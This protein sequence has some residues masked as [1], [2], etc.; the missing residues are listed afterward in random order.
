MAFKPHPSSTTPRKLHSSSSSSP[1]TS[2]SSSSSST[3]C[4]CN[5]IIIPTTLLFAL[6]LLFSSSSSSTIPLNLSASLS[7]TTTISRAT[8]PPAA[9]NWTGD[10]RQARFAWN[11]LC[12]GP[13]KAKLR[14]AAFSKKWPVGAVP[15]GMERHALGLYTALARAG[16]TVH[17]FTASPDAS[18]RLIHRASDGDLHVHFASRDGGLLDGAA[19]WK[20]FVEENTSRPFDFVHTESVALQH[21][22]ALTVPNLAATWH[23]IAYEALHSDLF[24]DLL[25]EPGQRRPAQSEARLRETIPKLLGEIRFFASYK[26]HIGI[27]DSVGQVLTDIYQLPPENVHVILNGVDHENFYH[28]PKIGARFRAEFGVPLDASLVMGVAGRL[29][30]DKGHQLL[31]E[32]FSAI[33]KRH[34]DVYLL[35]AG[36]GPWEERYR[37]LEPNVKVLGPLKPSR[38]AEFYNALDVFVNPTLRPQGLDLTLMEA[39]HCGKPLLASNFPSITGS[40]VLNEGFGYTFA[41]NVKSLTEAMESAI[42]DGRAELAGK[43]MTCKKYALSMFTARKMA[44]AYERFFLCMKD[45]KY[46]RR[47]DFHNARL[48]CH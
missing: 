16:H 3:S 12:F 19:A 37:E 10:L 28:D 45:V 27:S 42:R 17:V 20:L 26:H 46:C 22:R 7:C 13:P 33:R 36:S 44:S 4:F 6:L 25:R 38:L 43:G 39:M 32:A 35:V 24:Q 1:N 21:S 11:S 29:V 14:L 18:G 41:P 40:V 15:G 48:L 31:F 34:P 9:R 23:G 2:P 8:N 5:T 47:F 30:R